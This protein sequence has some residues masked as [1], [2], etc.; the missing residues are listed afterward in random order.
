MDNT[1][2]SKL[3]P[4][5]GSNDR[6]K[7]FW[8]QRYMQLFV[9]IGVL[10]LFVFSYVP[11]V[12][13]IISFK[14]YDIIDGFSG[15]FTSQWIGFKYFIE[16]FTDYNFP[17]IMKNTICISILKLIFTFPVPIIF[18]IMLNEVK[19]SKIKR[20]VQTASY[21]PYFIS[22]V[23]VSGFT[24]QF[25]NTQYGIINR[26]LLHFNII[27]EAQSFLTSPNYFWGIAVITGIWK[28]M[29]WWAIIFLAAIAGINP[30]LYEA[31][32]IDGAGRIQKIFYVTLPSIRPTIT[33]ILILALG[34]LIGGGMGGSTFEQSYLLGNAGNHEASDVIQTYAFRVGLSSG[35]Y[36]YATAV[37]LFQSIISLV[38]VFT[39]NKVSKKVS[40]SGLF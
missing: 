28:E 34:N 4:N 26:L 35:R 27:E 5:S 17:L 39:S 13:L 10:W 21:L 14:K 20:I 1:I 40:G 16:L 36:A 23:V 33:V 18:A 7:R 31:A 9:L 19:N 6:L 15:M 30:S 22:W 25:L 11:M 24:I 3:K 8:K 38:L 37:G 29:G 12:G 2:L 32:T